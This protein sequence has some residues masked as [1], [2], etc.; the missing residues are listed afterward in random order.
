M[1]KLATI[2]SFLLTKE[3]ATQ[4]KLQN[5]HYII[6][7]PKKF[8]TTSDPTFDLVIQNNRLSLIGPEIP[9]VTATREGV[10]T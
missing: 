1:K 4:L 3:L 7:I 5:Q 6:L 8:V 10:A 2:H 9:R